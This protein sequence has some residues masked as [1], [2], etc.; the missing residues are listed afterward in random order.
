MIATHTRNERASKQQCDDRSVSRARARPAGPWPGYVSEI[1]ISGRSSCS[2]RGAAALLR[3]CAF[4]LQL[5]HAERTSARLQAFANAVRTLMAL[6]LRGG[7]RIAYPW[8]GTA[9]SGPVCGASR[10]RR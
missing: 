5:Q 10:V 9:L 7:L 2:R 1:L 3:V 6:G 4:P 8:V